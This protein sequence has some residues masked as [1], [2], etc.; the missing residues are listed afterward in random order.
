MPAKGCVIPIVLVT[1]AGCMSAPPLQT[2][3]GRPEITLTAVDASCV[4]AA[5]LNKLVN[6]QWMVRSTTDTQIVAGK[7]SQNATANFL[8]RTDLGGRPEDRVTFLLIALPG[9]GMRVV[10][11][12]QFVS[13]AGTGFEKVTP[14]PH[15]QAVQDRF[16]MTGLEIQ[17]DCAKH[18]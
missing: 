13:N 3:S 2:A 18:G 11:S 1:A 4:R 15:A 9:D 16:E 8:L 14:I 5:L 12:E 17:Q 6:D 7:E 10:V